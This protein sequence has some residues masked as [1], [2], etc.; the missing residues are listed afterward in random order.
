[1][2]RG[3]GF[4]RR[5]AKRISRAV[6]AFER[7]DRDTSAV[8]FRQSGDD[9][10][11]RLCKTVASWAKGTSQTL[12]VWEDGTFPNEAQ[13]TGVT[14]EARNKYANIGSGKFVSIA[15][16]ANGEWYVIAAEC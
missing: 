15:L 1:M 12:Q 2:A 5:A 14:I 13:S 10:P 9:E 6:Q 11:L 8:T 3:G 4:T 16:H 7:G